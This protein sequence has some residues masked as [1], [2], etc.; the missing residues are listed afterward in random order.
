[1][2]LIGK[3]DKTATKVTVP[4]IIGQLPSA[5]EDA[6][7][8]Q[9]LTPQ[10]GPDTNGPCD[11]DRTVQKGQ[12]CSLE[13]PAGTKVAQNATVVYHLYT[14]KTVSVPS[15]I[16]KSYSDAANDLNNA[17]L[18]PVRKDVDN[19]APAGTVIGQSPDA[20]TPVPPGSKVTLQVS[21]GKVKLPDVRGKKL[22]DAR[23]TLNNSQ[24]TNIDSSQTAPTPDKA[25]AGTIAD[26]SPT[27]GI[28]YPLSTHVTLV[29]YKYVAPSPTCTTPT[30]TPSGTGSPT[31]S[32]SG[33]ATGTATP[34]TT[35]TTPG[36]LPPCTS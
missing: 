14:P 25:K 17:G 8:A 23:Q 4:S 2:M 22:A 5:G 6:L 18:V 21:T 33:T 12:I 20:F 15:E 3:S 36:A 28:S 7:R 31:D 16:N 11:E 9:K 24:Y 1:V 32:G 34:T 26:E 19:P 30:S 13:P 27:P 29:V 10:K 35:P